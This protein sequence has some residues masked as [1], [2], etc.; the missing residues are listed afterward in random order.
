MFSPTS[1]EIIYLTIDWD[2]NYNIVYALF[3][4]YQKI[5]RIFS[6]IIYCMQFYIPIIYVLFYLVLLLKILI[7]IICCILLGSIGCSSI[8]GLGYTST[9]NSRVRR[10]VWISIPISITNKTCSYSLCICMTTSR[11]ICCRIWISSSIGSN[12]LA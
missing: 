3:I 6:F 2:G 12:T 9:I 7:N 5:S 10:C 1:C 4:F 8:I 11:N